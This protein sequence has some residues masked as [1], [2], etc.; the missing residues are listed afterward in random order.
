MNPK[1]TPMLL[2]ALTVLTTAALANGN[3]LTNG[4]AEAGNLSGWTHTG[5]IAST[6]ITETMGHVSPHEGNWFFSIHT[7]SGGGGSMSQNGTTGLSSNQ[8]VL[9]G[10]VQTED[11]HYG[12]GIGEYAKIFLTIFDDQN[13][14]LVQE[15]SPIIRTLNLQWVP[16][17]LIAAVPQDADHWQVDLTGTMQEGSYV[18]VF[19]DAVSLT[20][21]PATLILAAAGLPFLLKRKHGRQ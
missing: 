5:A 6:G 10:M 7:N 9:N 11:L 8:L 14:P 19:Y 12:D 13:S 18:N 1:A 3:M 15:I 4:D 21:E 2:L 16:F 17:E 20:P